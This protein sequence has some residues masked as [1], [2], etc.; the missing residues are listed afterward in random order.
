[1]PRSAW[2]DGSA[3]LTI[4]ASSTTINCAMAITISARQRFGSSWFW[5]LAELATDM[6]LLE[7]ENCFLKS[8]LVTLNSPT[9]FYGKET[10]SALWAFYRLER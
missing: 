6:V 5:V 9:S 10:Y 1:M 7:F 3:M 8:V 4:E 2:I